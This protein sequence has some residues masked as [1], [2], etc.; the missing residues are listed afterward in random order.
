MSVIVEHPTNA[1]EPMLFTLSGITRDV[2]LQF[3]NALPPMLVTLFGIVMDA[4]FPQPVNAL[5]AMLVRL[6]AP[7]IVTVLKLVQ[8]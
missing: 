3:K 1:A 2:I 8:P 6:L 7:E 4:K 5:S